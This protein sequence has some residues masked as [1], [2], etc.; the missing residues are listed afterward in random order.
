[1]EEGNL[2]INC[3]LLTLSP[4]H[5]VKQASEDNP[6]H[7]VVNVVSFRASGPSFLHSLNDHNS[8]VLWLAPTKVRFHFF[9]FWLPPI[10]GATLL[11]CLR[12]KKNR[13]RPW[14]VARSLARYL[15]RRNYNIQSHLF[16][17]AHYTGEMECKTFV[18]ALSATWWWI[19][20][21]HLKKFEN[22]IKAAKENTTALKSFLYTFDFS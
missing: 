8:L 4:H 14:P 16:E 20:L 21:P 18:S 1:M 9:L 2:R 11:D 19:P 5:E 13:G 6:Q 15:W 10:L 7:F 12:P 3:W 22:E 17:I